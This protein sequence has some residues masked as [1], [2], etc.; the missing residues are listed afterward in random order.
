MTYSGLSLDGD[1]LLE[2]IDF[3]QCLSRVLDLPDDHCADFDRIAIEVI[4]FERR[5]LV[6]ADA[7]GDLDL[8]IEGV[9][10]AQSRLAHCADVLAVE[11][12][13]DSIARSHGRASLEQEHRGNEHDGP[14]TM[15]MTP[16]AA[17]ATVMMSPNTASRSARISRMTPP[18]M[19]K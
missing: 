12:Q 16:S 10:E 6:V 3:E 15:R 5:R 14:S 13:D 11:L 7:R 1:E 17:C 2:I 9:D 8:R 18:T 19:A 4:D